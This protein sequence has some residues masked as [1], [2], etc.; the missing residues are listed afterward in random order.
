MRE[1]L[2]LI[3]IVTGVDLACRENVNIMAEAHANALT[4]RGDYFCNDSQS[5][6]DDVTV[7]KSIMKY[8]IHVMK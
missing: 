8:T 6:H 5:W 3:G 4:K 7:S 1:K 2:E